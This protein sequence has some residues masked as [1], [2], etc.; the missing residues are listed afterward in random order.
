MT[1]NIQSKSYYFYPNVLLPY[2]SEP[3]TTKAPSIIPH[4]D[5]TNIQQ[6]LL[7]NDNLLSHDKIQ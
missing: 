5:T 6:S 7:D 4:R 3:I 1:C 2:A